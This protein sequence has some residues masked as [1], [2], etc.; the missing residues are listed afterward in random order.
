MIDEVKIRFGDVI[1]VQ[2]LNFDLHK[3]MSSFNE[4][5]SNKN[6]YS[7]FENEQNLYLNLEG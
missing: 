5:A 1:F 3:S 4:E 7:D 6:N 2:R